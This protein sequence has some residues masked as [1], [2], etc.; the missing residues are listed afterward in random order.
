MR[1]RW[2]GWLAAA[3]LVAATLWVYWPV[4]GYGTVGYDDPIYLE[5]NPVVMQ[6]LSGEG[7]VWALTTGHASNWH[8]LTWLS[9]MLDVELFGRDWGAHH[10]VS[11]VLHALSAVLLLLFLE[12]ATGRLGPAMAAAAL[13]ALHP[14]HVESVAWLSERKDVL[15]TLLAWVA[16]LAYLG[17]CWRPTRGRYAAVV[18]LLVL[19]LAA[20]PMLVTLPFVLL[21]LDL[22]PLERWAPAQGWPALRPR[23]VEK[24]PLFA[25]ALASSVVTLVVQRAGGAVSGLA[26]VPLGER[27]AN[28]AVSY[29]A[30]LGKLLWPVDLAV[31]YPHRGMPLLTVWLGALVLLG[32][33]SVLAWRARRGRPWWTVGWAWYLGTLVPVIGLVQV[34]AQS[35]ADRYT[36]L[37]SV[38]L[39]VA[40][41]FS[42]AEL[43]PVFRISAA[44]WGRASAAVATGLVLLLAVAAHRQVEVWRDSETL[45]R[46]A[47]E[48]TGDNAVM[49]NLLGAT[50]LDKGDT[51]GALPYLRRS[52]ELDP[53]SAE[54]FNNL[55]VAAQREGRSAD[56]LARF[57]AALDRDPGYAEARVNLAN[58]LVDEGRPQEALAEYE[59]VLATDPDDVAALHNL[60]LALAG[61]GRT[62][63]AERR[64]A[65]ALALDPD[66]P[67]LEGDLANA[68]LQLGR[69]D[70]ALEHYTRA[71][72]RAPG[73]VF[74]RINRAQALALA[75]RLGEARN[76]LEAVVRSAP[77]NP[78]AHFFLGLVAV[79][80]GDA[81][82]AAEQVQRLETL[83]PRLAEELS[84][85]AGG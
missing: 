26:G 41:A 35:M 18:V 17:W 4:T 39:F 38:G 23:L 31:F 32:V 48:A 62:A 69:A 3:V 54:V 27:L 43:G 52:A 28:A 76:E 5:D 6:G 7:L 78:R 30:Y 11:A 51:A 37:P 58:T 55:G 67:G 61:L 20:K 70:A 44:A 59:K 84:R 56:A 12:R 25:L 21:L 14:I 22:W 9:H 65:A 82:A 74:V 49:A 24:L 15:S 77:A 33:L 71:L 80:T 42:V 16:L 47:L 60:G 1:D 19:G 73:D 66:R 45:F 81:Q 8:P 10:A 34:G 29:V 79:A 40:A 83:D 50:L 75:G 46:H 36:Y 85:R 63:E 68:L 53:S 13:F 64:F 2:R 72:E 57:R